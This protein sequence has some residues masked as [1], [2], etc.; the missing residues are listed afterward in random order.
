MYKYNMYGTLR[1]V[2]HS[3][4]RVMNNN[5]PKKETKTIHH[6]YPRTLSPTQKPYSPPQKPKPS[7]P[8]PYHPQNT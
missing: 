2:H 6:P 8:Q 4:I 1:Y 3:I 5:T 7:R